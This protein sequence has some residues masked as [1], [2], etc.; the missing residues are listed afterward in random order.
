VSGVS[1]NDGVRSSFGSKTVLSE[2]SAH[3]QDATA[4]QGARKICAT[5]VRI[6]INEAF[7]GTKETPFSCTIFLYSIPIDNLVSRRKWSIF[8]LVAA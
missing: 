1:L 4:N 2:T 8:A 6:G 7:R 5:N 3:I